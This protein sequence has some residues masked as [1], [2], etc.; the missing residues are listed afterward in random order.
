MPTKII[1][2]AFDANNRI[3]YD[4]RFVGPNTRL[5]NGR[6]KIRM[7]GAAA[8]ARRRLRRSKP[9]GISLKAFTK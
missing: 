2:V 3:V 1:P 6:W 4:G 5:E 7:R 9:T 8:L